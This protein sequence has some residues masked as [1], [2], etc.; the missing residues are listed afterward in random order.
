MKRYLNNITPIMFLWLMT[1]MLSACQV[2]A[3]RNGND[4]RNANKISNKPTQDSEADPIG[5]IDK[6]ALNPIGL[7]K[8][9]QQFT[10]DGH[11]RLARKE[12]FNLPDAALERKI[13]ANKD[14]MKNS[15]LSDSEKKRIIESTIREQYYQ[16]IICPVLGAGDFNHDGNW[17]DLAVI[18]VD[19]SKSDSERFGLLIFNAQKN[20][21]DIYIPCWLFQNRDLS[22]T[23]LNAIKDNLIITE[24]RDDGYSINHAVVWDST[25]N[26]Y[27]CDQ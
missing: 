27:I 11:Y 10:A 2:S 21:E 25:K 22:K 8:A 26:R 17:Y 23:V 7:K 3:D 19:V 5:C 9:W 4:L 14:A 18:V 13:E 16:K 6:D 24:L 12:D 15:G 20:Q 1:C